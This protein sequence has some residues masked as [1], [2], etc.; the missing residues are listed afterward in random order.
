MEGKVTG[1]LV[2]TRTKQEHVKLIAA[3]WQRGVEDVIETGER[4]AAAKLE[5]PHGEFEAMVEVDLPFGPR[6]ARR[7]MAVAQHPVISN[8]THASVLPPSWMTLYEL[9]RVPTEILTA[10]IEDHTI[11]PKIER[12]NVLALYER[13]A[14][15]KKKRR[16]GKPLVPRER[17]PEEK[18]KEKRERDLQFLVSA[19]GMACEAA[20]AK[21][22]HACWDEIVRAHDQAG[23]AKPN[24]NAGA[25]HW[26]HLSKENAEAVDRW[27]ES[28]T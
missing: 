16:R 22:V 1:T 12:K 13:P 27:I 23:P 17:T 5:L 26:A 28:D 21:F 15:Q 24:G 20:R 18:Q 4:I 10:R 6:T 2:K 14:R 3:A 7:L 11:N 25:D 8:R 9:T 19:W